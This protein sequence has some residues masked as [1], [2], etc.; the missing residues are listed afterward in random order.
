MNS[1]S[2]QGYSDLSD[3]FDVLSELIV[4]D[5]STFLVVTIVRLK[6]ADF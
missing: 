2:N 5:D 4:F 3:R 6:L 1:R